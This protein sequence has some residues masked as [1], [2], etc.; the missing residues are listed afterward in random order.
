MFIVFLLL[1]LYAIEL[2]K[3]IGI[4]VLSLRSLHNYNETHC[5][6]VSGEK[7]LKPVQLNVLMAAVVIRKYNNI[8]YECQR[9][10]YL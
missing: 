4:S 6:I 7:Q 3:V 9:R 10:C 5:A 8:G 2:E 1:A